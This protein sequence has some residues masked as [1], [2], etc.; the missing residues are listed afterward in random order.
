MFFLSQQRYQEITSDAAYLDGI[1]SEGARKA[2]EIADAT[3]SNVYQA[4]GF[5]KR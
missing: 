2:S 3:V 1:L 4:M 5:L